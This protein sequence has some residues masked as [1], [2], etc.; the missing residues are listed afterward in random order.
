MYRYVNHCYVPVFWF[1]IG[2]I[3]GNHHF[4]FSF[5]DYER[6]TAHFSTPGQ[7]CI[8]FFFNFYK[9]H[10]CLTDIMNQWHIY[11]LIFPLSPLKRKK[12]NQLKSDLQ[13]C[14][15]FFFK[16]IISGYPSLFLSFNLSLFLHELVLHNKFIT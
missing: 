2:V 13:M 8:I 7:S 12:K 14:P 15:F 9:V 5:V 3:A 1:V 11:R 6:K 16:L 4:V 10:V